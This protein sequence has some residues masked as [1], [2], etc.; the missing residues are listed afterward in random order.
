LAITFGVV[1]KSMIGAFKHAVLENSALRKRHTLVNAAII[2]RTHFATA[3]T[4]YEYR[5]ARNLA[6][7]R[8][9]HWKFL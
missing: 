1:T 2:K 8:L 5:F 4:P 3:G 9:V 7:L 6:A